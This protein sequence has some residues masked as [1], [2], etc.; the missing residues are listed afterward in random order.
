MVDSNIASSPCL[1]EAESI[2]KMYGSWTALHAVDFH[3]DEGEV[4][5]IVGSSG[6]GKSTLLRCLNQLEEIQAGTIKYRGELLGVRETPKGYVRLRPSRIIDQRR[7]FGMV[8]QAFNLFPHMTA[9]ENVLA[10]PRYV[11]N[12]PVKT[13][14]DEAKGILSSVGLADKA[15]QYPNQLSGGQQQRVAIAR[16]MA[17]SPDVYLFDEPTS[18]LDPELVE[19]VLEVI[20][21]LAAEGKTM[22]IVTHEMSFA[23]SVSDRVIYMD[24]GR[25]VESGSPEKVMDSPTSERA[26]RFFATSAA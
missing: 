25:V 11:L 21:K 5:S 16:A 15:D 9:L 22:V 24:H 10:G 26:K 18:A 6:S 3:V 17:M 23:R 20:K 1:L 8:F 7:H 12:R 2:V 19:E 4:L 13:F 14:R